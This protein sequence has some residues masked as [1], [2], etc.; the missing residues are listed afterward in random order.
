ML[1]VLYLDTDIYIFDNKHIWITIMVIWIIYSWQ[2]LRHR[3]SKY[4]PESCILI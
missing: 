3:K 1:S 2:E 4:S